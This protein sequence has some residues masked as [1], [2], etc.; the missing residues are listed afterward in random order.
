MDDCTSIGKAFSILKIAPEEELQNFIADIKAVVHRFTKLSLVDRA[1]LNSLDKSGYGHTPEDSGPDDNEVAAEDESTTSSPTGH[2]SPEPFVPPATPASAGSAAED[3]ILSVPLPSPAPPANDGTP[4]EGSVPP[5]PPT[6]DRATVGCG[7]DVT[8]N[9]PRTAC[10]T[11][12]QFEDAPEDVQK[13]ISSVR[14]MRDNILA[15]MGRSISDSVMGNRHWTMEDRRILDIEFADGKRDKSPQGQFRRVLATLS[16]AQQFLSWQHP[17]ARLARPQRSVKAFSAQYHFDSRTTVENAISRGRKLLCIA[18]QARLPSISTIS[19]FTWTTYR[20]INDGNIPSLLVHFEAQEPALYQTL[21][22]RIQW[23]TQCQE[24]YE[25]KSCIDIHRSLCSRWLDYS[26]P[27]TQQPSRL[28][29][30]PQ[31]LDILV[32]A[33]MSD[34]TGVYLTSA[35]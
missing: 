15:H 9:N 35:D 22:D 10:L 19:A 18:K 6:C 3:A 24:F 26:Q 5:A 34:A 2:A 1:C 7:L 23:F 8:D 33:A 28:L 29:Q 20:N 32:E 17:R 25:C 12:L 30:G 31:T 13:L 27:R 4:V 16:L 14:K 11:H 21:R